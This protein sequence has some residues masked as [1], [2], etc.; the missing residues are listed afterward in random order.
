MVWM[1]V[2]IESYGEVVGCVT[3]LEWQAVDSARYS[4]AL[5]SQSEPGT[6]P[7]G[8]VAQREQMDHGKTSHARILRNRACHGGP[9][10]WI[11]L[12][13][14]SGPIAEVPK[15]KHGHTGTAD[16]VRKWVNSSKMKWIHPVRRAKFHDK[17]QKAL[18][19]QFHNPLDG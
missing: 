1:G 10:R 7:V 15:R 6:E 2:E 14:G 19:R 8:V 18:C 13:L 4:V 9:H 17:A 12:P 5:R 11:D 3:R 16:G